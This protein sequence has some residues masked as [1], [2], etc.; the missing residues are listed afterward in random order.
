MILLLIQIVA[1]VKIR[2]EQTFIPDDWISSTYLKK[3][4]ER[5]GV[6]SEGFIQSF[7]KNF[8]RFGKKR[9]SKVA[10]PIHVNCVSSESQ[11]SCRLLFLQEL[12]ERYSQHSDHFK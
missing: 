5:K 1:A 12:L 9:V 11:R 7:H 6:E 8:G 3:C 10:K 4:F 2:T